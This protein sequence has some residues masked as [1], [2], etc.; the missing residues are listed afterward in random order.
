MD[1]VP[2]SPPTSGPRGRTATNRPPQSPSS[3]RPQ[4]RGT[5][6]R[7]TATRGTVRP[8]GVRSGPVDRWWTTVTVL[9]LMVASEYKLRLRADDQAIAGSADP[10]ILLEI[11]CYAAVA[12]FLV[13]RFGLSVRPT[14]VR[15]VVFAAFAFVAVLVVSAAGSPYLSLALVR[16]A[17]LVVVLVLSRVI[18]RQGTRA[19][20]HRLGHGFAALVAA[21]VAFGV[22]VP[23]P[24]LPL[25]QD[26]FS[27]LY[28]HPVVAGEYVGIATV[29]LTGYLASRSVGRPGPR[30]GWPAYAGLLVV[31]AGGLIATKTRGAIAGAVVGVL[32]V[33][34]SL[35]QGRRRL[36]LA[37]VVIGVVSVAALVGASAVQSFLTR[38]E[39]AAQL[40]SLN[41]RTTLWTAA[42]H[43]F[44]ENPL[45]GYGLGASRGLFLA[46]I[47]LGGGHNALINVLV[48][49]GLAGA[50]CWL[51]L[52]T[53]LVVAVVRVPYA[54]DGVTVDRALML[55]VIGFLLT[56]SVFTEGLGAAANVASTWLFVIVGWTDLLLNRA[57]GVRPAP[58]R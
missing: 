26:R 1:V 28:V 34:W 13:R 25:Q 46:T 19:G 50:L 58:G 54:A 18:A 57:A 56:D 40:A 33:L 49:A 44:A 10:F 2:R 17:Q 14:R 31:C 15:P 11:A 53:T 4:T 36:D 43:A 21:S 48:D 35:R 30:L 27:W 12:A 52:L 47:G 6:T 37:A 22:A 41:S 45:Y 7:G 24:R 20:L 5:Q 23:F 9:V 39:S 42:L 51:A 8:A 16:A 38:G 32:L 55:G 29:L 3:R